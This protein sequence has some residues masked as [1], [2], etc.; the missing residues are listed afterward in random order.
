MRARL[1]S[2]A[3]SASDGRLPR[4]LTDEACRSGT[5]RHPWSTSL[6][7]SL[8]FLSRGRKCISTPTLSWQLQ[9]LVCF[10][11]FPIRALLYGTSFDLE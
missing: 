5:Y 4:W 1:S 7:A 2:L 11:E 9:K 10:L 3:A 8:R 6:L